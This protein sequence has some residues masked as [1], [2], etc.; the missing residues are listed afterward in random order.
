MADITGKVVVVTAAA[1][2]I[3]LASALAFAKA[4]AIVHATDINEA[5]LADLAKTPG[6]S[7]RKL[8]VLNDEAVKAA[9]AEIGR[10]DALFNCAG[11]VH[12]G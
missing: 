9:F 6:I 2:G 12:A 3:G 4:G 1:Q 10:V 5:A 11:F 7:P 8:D